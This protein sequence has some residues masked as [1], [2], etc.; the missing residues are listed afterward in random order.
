MNN[1]FYTYHNKKSTYMKQVRL[2]IIPELKLQPEYDWLRMPVPTCIRIYTF[3]ALFH[4]L[5]MRFTSL[6]NNWSIFTSR[7]T[8]SFTSELTNIYSHYTHLQRN[9]SPLIHRRIYP[10]DEKIKYDSTSSCF[11]FTN[12]R[13]RDEYK[14]LTSNCKWLNDYHCL[15]SE[16]SHH[17]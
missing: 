5:K 17:K 9:L 8:T 7:H 16:R 2:F 14:L 6:I 15:L 11:L 1:N 12:S 10:C 3:F 13:M 4:P